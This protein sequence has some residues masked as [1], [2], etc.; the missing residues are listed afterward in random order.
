[1]LTF[2]TEPVTDR[3]TRIFAHCG[4]MAYLVEGDDRAALLDTASGFGS[5]RAAVEALTDKPVI[6]LTTHGHIDHAMGSAEFPEVY[7]SHKD[8]YVYDVHGEEGLRRAMLPEEVRARMEPEE[9][10]PTAPF[11]LY[12]DL[13]GGDSFP[14]GGET[15]EIY[16]CPGHT[17]GSV[18]MLMKE[19]RILL[20]GDACNN[21]TFLFQDYSTSVAAYAESLR[22]LIPQV[23]GKYDRV[24]ASHAGGE[25]APDVLEGVLQV[26]EDIMAGKADDVPF[27]FLQDTGWLAKRQNQNGQRL[28][29]GHGNVVYSREHIWREW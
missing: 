26:C 20:T 16:D 27:S 19:E 4:E 8:K 9:Y 23:A 12:R 15:V 17:R 1:M 25:L 21:C 22:R 13:K 6:V 14:L 5:L 24:L 18:V 29:G 7:L 28:D 11:S 10:I 3:I 2:R